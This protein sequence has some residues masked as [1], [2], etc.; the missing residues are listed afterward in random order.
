MKLLEIA[1]IKVF[2]TD[3]SEAAAQYTAFLARWACTQRPIDPLTF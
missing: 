2:K 3:E 1:S